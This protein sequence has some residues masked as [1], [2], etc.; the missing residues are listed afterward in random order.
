MVICSQLVAAAIGALKELMSALNEQV[1]TIRGTD[2]CTN[3]TGECVGGTDG[4][5]RME[6][7]DAP[8]Q[9]VKRYVR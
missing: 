4:C 3:E 2:E 5:E 9:G 7:I 1:G 8:V 6:Q